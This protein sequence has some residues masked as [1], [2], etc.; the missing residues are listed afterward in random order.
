MG[1][2]SD[3]ITFNAN[4]VRTVQKGWWGGTEQQPFNTN[5]T[6]SKTNRIGSISLN[7]AG[8]Y[9]FSNIVQSSE[10][11]FDF[12]FDSSGYFG[13]G[14]SSIRLNTSEWTNANHGI[15]FMQI[16]LPSGVEETYYKNMYIKYSDNELKKTLVYNEYKYGDYPVG[17]YTDIKNVITIEEE[18]SQDATATDTK[19]Y[20]KVNLQG[21]Y[22]TRK[23]IE[24]W[25]VERED[26]SV[27][28]S[29]TMHFVF[30]V[31]ITQEDIERGYVKIYASLLTKKDTRVFGT[32]NKVVGKIVNY[33]DADND[34]N[35]GEKQYY[36]LE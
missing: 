28:D 27:E 3:T 2:T 22:F 17:I 18:Q 20:I 7:D 25:Y 4:C 1:V 14:H 13:D 29:G 6:L 36:V 5:Y 24:F 21:I 19:V 26:D 32:N 23:S 15:T 10:M 33:Q 30:G 9:Y 12:A 31:N 35:Y 11:F 8:Y 16:G 34:K